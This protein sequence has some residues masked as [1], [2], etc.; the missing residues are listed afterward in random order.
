MQKADDKADKN[1]LFDFGFW[2][3]TILINERD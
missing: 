3:T 1:L 2:G